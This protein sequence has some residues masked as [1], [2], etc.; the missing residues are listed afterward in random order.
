MSL[1]RLIDKLRKH[2][3]CMEMN[4]P[5]SHHEVEKFEKNRIKLPASYVELLC[6]FDGGELFIPGTIIYGLNHESDGYVLKEINEK[7]NPPAMLG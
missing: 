6:C 3:E 7:P 1:H 2:T 5:L 4:E